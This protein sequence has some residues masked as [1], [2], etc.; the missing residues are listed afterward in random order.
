MSTRT[1]FGKEAK[2]DSE[3][4]Y[5]LKELLLRVIEK[6]NVDSMV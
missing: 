5:F 6:C 3:I 4:G 1:R 2:G